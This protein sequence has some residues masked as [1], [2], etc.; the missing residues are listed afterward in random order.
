MGEI[1]AI[2]DAAADIADASDVV[3]LERWRLEE[4]VRTVI[5]LSGDG[6][7]EVEVTPEMLD[8]GY[9]EYVKACLAEFPIEAD[10]LA[11]EK[12]Y[13]AMEDARRKPKEPA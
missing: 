3:G 1:G 6:P 2:I 11:I 9:A 12:I 8:A 7:C 4:L 5:N 13:R 10:K